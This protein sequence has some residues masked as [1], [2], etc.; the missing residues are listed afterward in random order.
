MR[1]QSC[2]N[3]CLY[4]DGGLKD[5]LELADDKKAIL[6]EKLSEELVALRAKAGLSQEELSNI[7][8]ISRQSYGAFELKKKEMTWRTC[9]SLIMY[10]EFNPRTHDMLHA[11]DLFPDELDEAKNIA[12]VAR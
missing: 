10:F 1:Y 12:T 8:G 3:N 11:L 9:F 4:N 5:L 6:I 7:L 2:G